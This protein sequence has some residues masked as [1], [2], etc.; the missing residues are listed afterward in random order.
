MS[1]YCFKNNNAEFFENEWRPALDNWSI[2]ETSS[3]ISK[4]KDLL[5]GIQNSALC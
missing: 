3:I 5:I 1:K 2:M 4:V